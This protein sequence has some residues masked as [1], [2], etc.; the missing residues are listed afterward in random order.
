MVA[1]SLK[2]HLGQSSMKQKLKRV[3]WVGT[4]WFMASTTSILIPLSW[5]G[6]VYPWNHW[7]TLVPLPLG[8]AGLFLLVYWELHVAVE[9]S[10]RLS[11]FRTLTAKVTFLTTFLQ[12]LIVRHLVH[13]LIWSI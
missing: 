12:G 8:V 13:Q 9:P 1:V 2:L 7:R 4:A 10:L 3:D 5:G 6:V 11:I